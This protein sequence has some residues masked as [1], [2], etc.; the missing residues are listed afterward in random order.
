[1]LMPAEM[2][3]GGPRKSWF[4]GDRRN[5]ESIYLF[6]YLYVYIN[7]PTWPLSI[8]PSIYLS[9][10]LSISQAIYLSASYLAIE[11][12]HAISVGPG[13]VVVISPTGRAESA[14]PAAP[15]LSQL[16]LA[17]A[18]WQMREG[19]RERHVY[20]QMYIYIYMYTQIHIYISYI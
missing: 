3:R 14:L 9:V 11:R 5:D 12:H 19:E 15:G 2:D 17:T 20:T 7:L 6:V 16:G 10:Y 18:C 13:S 8:H 1:M 4:S